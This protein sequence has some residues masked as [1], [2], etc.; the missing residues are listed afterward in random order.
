[1]SGI[2][3]TIIVTTDELE[4]EDAD[5]EADNEQWDEYCR[6]HPDDASEP[7]QAP[8]VLMSRL[9]AELAQ[10]EGDADSERVCCFIF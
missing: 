3:S 1:M 5:R 10:G 2:V 7:T 6:A 9:Y 8:T 4:Q